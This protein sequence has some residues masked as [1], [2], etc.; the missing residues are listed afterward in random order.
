MKIQSRPFRS[1][2]TF[3]SGGT[4]SKGRPEFWAGPIPWVSPKDMHG[5][6]VSEAEDHISE[7]AIAAS[8]TKLVEPGTILAVTRSGIL[9][10]K[11]PLAIVERTVA[12]N[13]DIKAIVVDRS[14]VDPE[15]AFWWLR[16]REHDVLRRGIKKGATVHSVVANFVEDM[17]IP[18]P[19]LEEQRRIVDVLNRAASV[20]R[21]RARADAAL[22][23]F[24]PAL[25]I[26]MF[27]DPV[28]NP[29]GWEVRPLGEVARIATGTTP[30]KKVNSY[31]GKDIPFVRPGD[32]REA[33]PI[34]DAEFWLSIKGA[35]VARISPRDTVLVC[36]IGSIGRMGISGREVAFNQ[37]INSLEFRRCVEPLFGFFAV[38]GIMS[39]IEA[40]ASKSTVSIINKS[41]FSVLEIPVPP[42]PLQT[43][44]AELV[45]TARGV[46]ATAETATTA[47]ASLSAALMSRLF[48]DAA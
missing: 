3:L 25:F 7:G 27:G 1:V 23:A 46:A 24:A 15:F 37:Q 47:A 41:R 31:Y 5:P 26:K 19:P 12:F 33:M 40:A 48:E 43:R 16:A 38:R 22:R 44:Y 13:Q 45:A 17:P 11:W 29:I 18:L 14:A 9:A 20:E 8:A 10:R 30:S 35:N 32:L 36:C 4:P 21:L 39:R 42:L 28:D 2:A 6:R 34:E